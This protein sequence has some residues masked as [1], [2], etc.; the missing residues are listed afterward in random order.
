VFAP[1]VTELIAGIEFAA[2]ENSLLVCSTVFIT[3]IWVCMVEKR[4]FIFLTNLNCGLKHVNEIS[5]FCYAIL[6]PAPRSKI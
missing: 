2:T 4:I 6:N 5:Q 3:V 1:N